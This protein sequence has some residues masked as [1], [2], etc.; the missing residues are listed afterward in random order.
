MSRGTEVSR[1][2]GRNLLACRSAAS[3]GCRA[4]FPLVRPAAHERPGPRHLSYG[5]D[6]I[7]PSTDGRDCNG[8]GTHVAGTVGGSTFGVAKDVNLVAVRVLDCQGSGTYAAVIAGVDYVTGNHTTGSAV[9]NMSLGGPT[10]SALDAAIRNSIADGVTYVVAAGNGNRAGV[11]QDACKFSPARVTEAITVGATDNTDRKAGFSNYGPCVDWFAPGVNI[12]S[13]A[14]GT[15][16]GGIAF[17]GTSMAAP[18]SAGVVALFLQKVP[19]ATPGQVRA[20][21]FAALT[22]DKVASAGKGT[23]NDHLLYSEVLPLP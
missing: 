12:L 16:S 1:S 7:V 10:S 2:G 21:M 13:A 15:G 3:A 18:H 9:A 20:A 5:H 22:K 17:S 8:H 23:T 19:A 4:Q 6:A 11:G 14:M